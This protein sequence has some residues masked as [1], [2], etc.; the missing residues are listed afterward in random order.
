[1][2]AWV[3][4][5]DSGHKVK[6]KTVALHVRAWVEMPSEG[7]ARYCPSLV[8]L[9]VRAW[10]EMRHLVCLPLIVRGRPPCEGV[11]RNQ[12]TLTSFPSRK[13]ALHVRAWV[14]MIKIDKANLN[15]N[16]ALHVRAW[17]EMVSVALYKIGFIMSPSM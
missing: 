7:F 9:H 4:I 11:G 14:E 16:V 5:E 15:A 6:I 2:R 12:S 3:E 10:V 1:M 13:V 17:V 8:A